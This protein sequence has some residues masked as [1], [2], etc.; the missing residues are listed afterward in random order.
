M[1]IG[2]DPEAA[3]YG[4]ADEESKY[5]YCSQP[6]RPEP[7]VEAGIDSDLEAIVVNRTK[8]V[9]GTI[10]HYYFFDRPTDG[11]NVTMSNGS[12]QFRPWTSDQA[13]K[14]LVR[15]AFGLW[16][17]LG[18]GLD[19]KEVP[20]REDAEI[21]IGFMQGD[22]SW[23]FLGR[24]ILAHGQNERTMNFGWKLAGRPDGI[25]TAIHEI[26]HT[27]GLPHEHQN[28][29]AGMVW[30]EERVYAELAK[31]PNSWPREKTHWN[32][33]RKLAPD[34]VQGS[35]WDADSVMHYPFKAGL[36]LRPEKYRT[37]ALE[38]AGG[39]SE[40]DRTWIRTF[41]PP[42]GNAALPKLKPFAS[43]KLSIKP[44]EQRDFSVVPTASRNYVFSTFGVADTVMVLFEEVDGELKFVVG[45]DD[46]GEGRNSKFQLK[47]FTGR[48]YVVRIRLYSAAKSG[49]TA[50]MMT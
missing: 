32:I 35:S 45:D 50:V 8:W 36:I 49:E 3:E 28:P 30:D 43:Q 33:I 34:T 39:L 16:K 46:S 25:D 4:E 12:V 1:N 40:R 37:Q 17:A 48:K 24:D 41:Y 22:G 21:R 31:P 26:G 42:I 11:E 13:H 29:N 27:L 18:I 20:R 2:Q 9:N 10:L 47:L 44:G 38:P 15:K 6:P 14:D 19:F 5:A 23:S 7:V